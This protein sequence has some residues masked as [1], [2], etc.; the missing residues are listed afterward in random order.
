MVENKLFK[1]F[2]NKEGFQYQEILR[3]N[4]MNPNSTLNNSKISEI[5]AFKTSK[6]T[7]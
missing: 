2:C 4:C 3:N 5:L 1:E 7:L 6:K